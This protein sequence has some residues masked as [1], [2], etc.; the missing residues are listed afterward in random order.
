M[1]SAT[2][3]VAMSPPIK[4]DPE[5]GAGRKGVREAQGK[6]ELLFLLDERK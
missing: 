2:T 3:R 5:V 4:N 6:T 1:K